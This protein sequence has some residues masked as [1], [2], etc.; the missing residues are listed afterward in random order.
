MQRRIHMQKKDTLVII[1]NG[2]DI[3]QLVTQIFKHIICNIEMR[4]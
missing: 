4:F 2:F 3:W 1:G